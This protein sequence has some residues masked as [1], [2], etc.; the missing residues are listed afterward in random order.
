MV[1]KRILPQTVGVERGF[2][3]A[4]AY[5]LYCAL[6]FCHCSICSTA[7]RQT[8]DPRALEPLTWTTAAGGDCLLVP[9]TIFRV[10]DVQLLPDKTPGA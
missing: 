9:F 2:G 3:M 6:S 10:P 5:Y 8:L 1:W 7:D 4:Q